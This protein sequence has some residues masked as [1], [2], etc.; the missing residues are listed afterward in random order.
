MHDDKNGAMV[1]ALRSLNRTKYSYTELLR[2]FGI[3]GEQMRLSDEEFDNNYYTYGLDF[4]GNMPLIEP[5][6]Y[7]ERK[8]IREFVIAIDTSGSVRGDVV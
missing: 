2:R 5:L 3:H 7:S 6:E 1:Q 4:Y 8:L